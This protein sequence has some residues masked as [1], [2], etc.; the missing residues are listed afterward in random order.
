MPAHAY[1]GKNI[2]VVEDDLATREGL[3]AVLEAAGC[4]VRGAVNGLEALRLLREGLQVDLIL[5]DL[6]MPVLDGWQFRREQQHDPALALIPVVVVSAAS[7][8]AQEVNNLGAAAAVPKPFEFDRLLEVVG[9]LMTP[10]ATGV[11]IVDDEPQVRKLL[12]YALQHNGFAT[13]AAAGGGEGIEIYREHRGEVG[14]VLLDVQMPDLD[15][16]QTL[17][18]LQKIDPEVRCC[19]MS[20][21]TGAYTAEELLALGASHIFQKP[22]GLA[23]LARTLQGMMRARPAPV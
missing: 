18:A 21:N 10:A 1:S 17:T 12:T 19:F 2:L 3:I 9:E 8:L 14:V 16:P 11:L 23:D 22:F 7:D 5:L 6:R 4:H 13:W 20:G 15:G